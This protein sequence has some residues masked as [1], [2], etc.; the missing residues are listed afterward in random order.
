M[1][2]TTYKAN[3]KARKQIII[4]LKHIH[5]ETPTL[6]LPSHLPQTK[7]INPI[8]NQTTRTTTKNTRNTLKQLP[9]LHMPLKKLYD[10]LLSI[11][12]I[13]PIVLPPQPHFV[14]WYKPKLTC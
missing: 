11:E 9:P 3:I 1:M 13:A 6:P 8:I 12:H 5:L 4:T 14:V 10:K 7:P 2:L